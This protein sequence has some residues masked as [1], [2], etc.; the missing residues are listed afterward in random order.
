MSVSV[1][2]AARLDPAGTAGAQRLA[3]VYGR[4]AQARIA[5]LWRELES[6]PQADHAAL[7]RA[8]LT[9]ALSENLLSGSS[10]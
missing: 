9:G 10:A 8:W 3:D 6:P 4:G 5:A 7:S 2:R 1:A